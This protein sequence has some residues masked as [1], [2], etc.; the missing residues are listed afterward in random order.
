MESGRFFGAGAQGACCKR[1]G[2]RRGSV[3]GAHNVCARKYSFFFSFRAAAK[4][5]GGFLQ[6]EMSVVRTSNTSPPFPRLLQ[7]APCAPAPKIAPFAFFM[8]GTVHSKKN[9]SIFLLFICYEN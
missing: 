9:Y 6:R 1:R 2:E 7:Q 5:G 8:T 3:G 4:M